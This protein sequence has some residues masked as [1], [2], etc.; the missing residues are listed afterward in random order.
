MNNPC[1]SSTPHPHVS[2]STSM[3]KKPNVT[4]TSQAPLVCPSVFFFS[5][6]RP[7]FFSYMKQHVSVT[8]GHDDNKSK[9]KGS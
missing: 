4:H 2:H 7:F 8:E 5:R 6:V 3:P 1:N 9:L